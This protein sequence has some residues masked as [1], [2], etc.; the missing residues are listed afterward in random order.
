MLKLFMT[1][2]LIMALGIGLT[3]MGYAN[4]DARSFL[5]PFDGILAVIGGLGLF[6]W[7]IVRLLR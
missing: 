5:W 2:P 6:I 4:P 1:G 3:S 7:A